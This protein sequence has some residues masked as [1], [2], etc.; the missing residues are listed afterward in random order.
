MGREHT[1]AVTLIK[2]GQGIPHVEVGAYRYTADWLPQVGETIPIRSAAAPEGEGLELQG[3][4]T[5]VNPVSDAPISVVEVEGQG[6]EDDVVVQP[7][8]QVETY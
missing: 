3:Y 7:G 2:A 8:G 5:K 4:V 6:I 1:Y